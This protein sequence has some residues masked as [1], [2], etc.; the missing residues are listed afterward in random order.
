MVKK[1]KLNRELRELKNIRTT[2]IENC[3]DITQTLKALAHPARLKILCHLLDG[4]KT[5]N[6]LM[7]FC[8]SSQS[9]VSQFLGRMKLEGLVDSRRNGHYVYYRISNEKIHRLIKVLKEIYAA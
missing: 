4:E 6:E 2:L 5:V 8:E 9:G 1:K 3:L 7:E